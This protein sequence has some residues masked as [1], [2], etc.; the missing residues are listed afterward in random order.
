MTKKKGGASYSDGWISSSIYQRLWHR[1]F[2]FRARTYERKLVDSFRLFFH[3]ISSQWKPQTNVTRKF[4]KI[5][6]NAWTRGIEKRKC[7][8]ISQTMEY[9]EWMKHFANCHREPTKS[10]M[11]MISWIIFNEN[12]S[13]T[14]SV[15]TSSR[16]TAYLC[17]VKRIVFPRNINVRSEGNSR[18]KSNSC[19]DV[20]GD[21]IIV[22][23]LVFVADRP[24]MVISRREVANYIVL[25]YLIEEK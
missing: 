14:C 15:G 25:R 13:R 20:S 19:F 12:H 18:W 6:K 21:L 1:F 10:W 8:S 2:L 17:Q 4:F 5:G 7:F 3:E 24:V 22:Q 9:F 23:Q 11:L 16:V